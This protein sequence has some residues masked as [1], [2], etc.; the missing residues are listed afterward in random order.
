MGPAQAMMT[1][2]SPGGRPTLA[3]AAELLRVP[4]SSM[5]E[6]FGVVLIDPER[7]LYAVR[8]DAD[9]LAVDEPSDPRVKGPFANPRIEPLDD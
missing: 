3:A 6:T 7:R 9:A 2:Q 1:I 8:V 5:D 4:V